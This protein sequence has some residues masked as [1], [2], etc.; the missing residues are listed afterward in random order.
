MNLRKTIGPLALASC[1]ALT[2]CDFNGGVEQ[3][4]CV[5][6]NEKDNSVTLVVDSAI[7]QHNPHYSGAVDTY[8]LPTDPRDMGP[9][10]VAGGLLMVEPSKKEAIIYNPETKK[11]ETLAINVEDEVKGL[12]PNDPKIKG[13]TFPEVNK[14]THVVTV[15]SPRLGELISFKPADPAAFNL[16]DFV[17]QYGDE[18]RIAFKKDMKDQAVRFMNV[19]KTNIFAR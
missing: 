16:P 7:D 18:V 12:A 13:R 1:L 4:R 9:A 17:W 10:P 3:G 11:Q 2:A 8:K 6:Y 19:S 14:E 5:A 15:Y